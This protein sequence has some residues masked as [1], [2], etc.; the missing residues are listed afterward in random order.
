[1][2]QSMYAGTLGLQAHQQAM[3]VVGNNVANVNTVGFKYS[4]ANF[5]E[6]LNQTMVA[7]SGPSGGMG[8]TNGLQVGLG[9]EVGS[10]TKIF[11]QGSLEPTDRNT[12]L[13]LTGDGM[14]V[15]S[16]DGGRTNQYSRAGDFDFDRAGNL[17]NPAGNIVQGWN[18]DSDFYVDATTP[19]EGINIDPKLKIPANPTKVI[20]AKGNLNSE[21]SIKSLFNLK[22]GETITID[23]ATYT[24]R[25]ATAEAGEF[26]SAQDLATALG[27]TIVDGK[28]QVG[29]SFTSVSGENT[30]LVNALTP[31]MG[32]T[33]SKKVAPYYALSLDVYDSLGEKSTI[34]V[35]F[36]KLNPTGTAG[37][38]G[39]ANN[40]Q[41][42]QAQW[43]VTVESQAPVDIGDEIAGAGQREVTGVVR[44]NADGSISSLTPTGFAMTANNT[45]EPN[46]RIALNFGSKFDGLTSLAQSS[47]MSDLYQDGYASGDLTD[48]NID[49]SGMI[50]GTFSNQEIKTLGQVAVAQ[51]KN[52]EGLSNIGSNLYSSTK[53]SGEPT[54][55]IAGLGGR[56]GIKSSTLEMSNA[57]LSNSLT[58][59]IVIQRGFQANS[60]TITTTDTMLDTLINMKR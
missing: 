35:K 14:F 59:L 42:A 38:V 34:A 13:A 5:S 43:S 56:S 8:G 55:G 18:K 23:G 7:S 10:S 52:N 53:S 26:H 4:R 32:G 1:M 54:V 19:I 16:S 24:Y 21:E 49:D 11:K 48:V 33:E 44:F 27:A 2:V 50:I 22:D 15:L 12:D 20:N 60:K 46:Q 25:D 31:L 39:G 3:D 6:M 37:N 41:V 40:Q 9:A 29:D 45:S 51:F 36:N 57:D 30:D 47:N 58:Q 28:F 17:T